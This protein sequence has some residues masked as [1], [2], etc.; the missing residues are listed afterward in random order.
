MIDLVVLGKVFL[1]F[2]GGLVWILF[3]Q[4]IC[5]GVTD[6]EY[7]TKET[8]FTLLLWPLIILLV[9]SIVVGGLIVACHRAIK[10]QTTF[11]EELKK[12]ADWLDNL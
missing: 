9:V 2:L 11:D 4:R 12:I 10:N 3:C 7:S 5:R 1:Y 8:L 6:M